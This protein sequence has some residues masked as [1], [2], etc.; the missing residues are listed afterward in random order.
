M[1]VSAT[2]GSFNHRHFREVRYHETGNFSGNIWGEKLFIYV[3]SNHF[4]NWINVIGWFALGLA[5]RNE[6]VCVGS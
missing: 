6:K 2:A 4:I 1:L 3:L 5:D